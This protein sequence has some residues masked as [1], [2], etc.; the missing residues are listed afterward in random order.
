MEPANSL[1][2][3]SRILVIVAHADDIE[4]SV[5]GSVARWVQEG[6]KVTYCVIT[7]NG[8]G[9]NEPGVVRSDLVQRREAEQRAAAALVGVT[10][11]RFLGYPDGELEPTVA[12]RK[13]LTRLIREIRPQRVVCQD[14][15]T[16]YV[17][18]WYINHPDHRAAGEA[19]I[20]A[21][22]PSACTR[23]VFA[24]LLDQGYE[25]YNVKELFLMLNLEPT[26]FVDISD[27][28]EVKIQALLCH[29]SQVGPDVQERILERNAMLGGKAGFAYAEGFRVMQFDAPDEDELLEDAA[30][31][32]ASMESIAPA[33]E[34]G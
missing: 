17:G 2:T 4:F 29:E 19:A 25:P 16:V 22:F 32:A 8:A 27:T 11:I 30:A 20:Y 7:D 6:A 33:E 1:K 31:S 12:L 15:T 3:P 14:P 24:D 10:D 9:S 28:I 26:Y 34:A 13:D 21:V 23:P 5:A 18:D